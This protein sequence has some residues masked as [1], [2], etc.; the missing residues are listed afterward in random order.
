MKNKKII[1]LATA[2]VVSVNM[3]PLNLITSYADEIVVQ[4]TENQEN[5]E[6]EINAKAA[7][8]RTLTAKVK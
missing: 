1:S 3:M 6:K 4:E 2:S 8:Q 7:T 5:M